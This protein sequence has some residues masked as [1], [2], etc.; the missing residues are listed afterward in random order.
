MRN[1]GRCWCCTLRVLRCF[2]NWGCHFDMVLE[3][4]A[5]W[6]AGWNDRA[7]PHVSQKKE[8][9]TWA[10]MS[11]YDAG[12][13]CQ[14]NRLCVWQPTV[15][16]RFVK[17]SVWSEI[18]WSKTLC[19]FAI[20]LLSQTV[21]ILSAVPT[22]CLSLSVIFKDGVAL[23]LLWM[24]TVRYFAVEALSF[25]VSFLYCLPLT[26]FIAKREVSVLIEFIPMC[27]Q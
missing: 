24:P 9:D 4:R 15:R 6:I 25:I 14:Q 22:R 13:L 27:L 8:L 17:N 21:T 26:E 16:R 10:G 19:N 1:V 11:C 18:N 12:A 7:R 20:C 5:G 2:K 3:G 23:S